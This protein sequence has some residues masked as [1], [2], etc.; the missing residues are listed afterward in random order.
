M[1]RL[2]LTV[3]FGA[4]ALALPAAAADAP[5]KPVAAKPAPAGNRMDVATG[6][7]HR[8]HTGKLKLACDTCHDTKTVDVLVVKKA[9]GPG[10]P[11]PINRESCRGCHQAPGKPT[12]YGAPK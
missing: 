7:F 8:K 1:K 5:P 9:D 3:L 10:S 6:S 4:I 11:G 12:W 2:I